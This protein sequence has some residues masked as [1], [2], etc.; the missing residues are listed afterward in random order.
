MNLI[1]VHCLQTLL[2]VSFFLDSLLVHF[3]GGSMHWKPNVDKL[4]LAWLANRTP[5]S[6]IRVNI[7]SM[8]LAIN[9]NTNVVKEAPCM[10]YIRELRSVLTILAKCLA[11]KVVGMSKQMMQIHNNATSHKGTKILI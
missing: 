11:G 9:P 7:V 6:C 5:P 8:A 2:K 10:K 1:V 3:I 4:I